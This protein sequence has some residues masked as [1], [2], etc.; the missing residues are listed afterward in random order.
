MLIQDIDEDVFEKICLA[1]EHELNKA[2]VKNL[3][4]QCE[5]NGSIE[6]Y[7]LNEPN[8]E[9]E[10]FVGRKHTAIKRTIAYIGMLT[11]ASILSIQLLNTAKPAN[12]DPDTGFFH[13]LKKDHEIVEFITN[14][15]SRVLGVN[16]SELPKEGLLDLLSEAYYTPDLMPPEMLINN[17][18]YSP[19][20]DNYT[21]YYTDGNHYVEMGF[22]P[23]KGYDAEEKGYEYYGSIFTSLN[24]S[25]FYTKGSES[26]G[27]YPFHNRMYY[28]R[29]NLD[30][31]TIRDMTIEYAAYLYGSAHPDEE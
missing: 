5:S 30:F 9:E 19:E 31:D 15:Q 3:L 23:R 21:A 17:I 22:L 7:Y 10:P 4:M 27:T 16:P 28:I 14:P 8:D 13:W 26:L 12:A 2:E 11:A 24:I 20:A 25:M 29:G 18:K 6:E 1:P